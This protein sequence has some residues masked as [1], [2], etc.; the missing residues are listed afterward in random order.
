MKKKSQAN[1]YDE[2][3]GQLESFQMSWFKK[4]LKTRCYWLALP[5][6]VTL[7]VYKWSASASRQ[8]FYI[9]LHENDIYYFV[10]F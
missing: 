2:K 10:V 7:Y 3:L 5:L 9:L 4:Q 8:H 1:V 6:V